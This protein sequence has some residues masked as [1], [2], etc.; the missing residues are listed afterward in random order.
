MKK[1][2]LLV[3]LFILFLFACN[4]EKKQSFLS[5]DNI[6]TQIFSID[7]SKE[8][9]INGTRGG[10][11]TIPAGAFEGMGG[12]NSKGSNDD[13]NKRK[14]TGNRQNQKRYQPDF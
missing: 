3:A 9:R 14:G 5:T 8:N 7:P 4:R 12:S 10:I 2:S 1:A 13:S 6:R 11:F